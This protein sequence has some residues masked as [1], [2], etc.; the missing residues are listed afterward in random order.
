MI[1]RWTR[2]GNGVRRGLRSYAG[3]AGKSAASFRTVFM[4]RMVEVGSLSVFI[5]GK[6]QT[7][8]SLARSL[9]RTNSPRAADF[10]VNTLDSVA[11]TPEVLPPGKPCQIYGNTSEQSNDGRVLHSRSY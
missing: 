3:D 10:S 2:P 4:L 7:F 8:D 9:W 11:E 1:S 5:A 6:L